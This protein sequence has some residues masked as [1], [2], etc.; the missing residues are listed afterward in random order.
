MA[1]HF[2]SSFPHD[3]EEKKTCP[4]SDF[5][6]TTKEASQSQDTLTRGFNHTGS[7]F[8]YGAAFV[9]LPKTTKQ[10]GENFLTGIGGPAAVPGGRGRQ[11]QA[12]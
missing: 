8:E 12:G 5:G 7:H 9:R 11:V 10:D 6:C 3:D 2:L 1:L 4:N